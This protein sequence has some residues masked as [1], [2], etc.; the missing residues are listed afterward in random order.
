MPWQSSGAGYDSPRQT[1]TQMSLLSRIVEDVPQLKRGQVWCVSCGAT[2]KVNAT[3]CLG[4]GWPMC[5]GQTM[6]IDSPEERDAFNAQQK[7]GRK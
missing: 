2:Y 1:G 7:R 3:N 6:S 4:S 5:C